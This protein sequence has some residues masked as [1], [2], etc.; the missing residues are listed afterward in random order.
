MMYVV[1]DKQQNV[2]SWGTSPTG[3]PAV[4]GDRLVYEVKELPTTPLHRWKFV[5]GAF[6]DQ[7][8]I[9]KSTYVE[10]RAAAYPSIGEQLDVLW[11]TLGSTLK[12]KPE[13][14]DMLARIESV[15][16]RYPKSKA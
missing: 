12:G 3:L 15:K 16:A 13:A 10:Q 4:D 6:V 5:K 8:P 7:G 2:L 1:V 11:K 14:E 9:K